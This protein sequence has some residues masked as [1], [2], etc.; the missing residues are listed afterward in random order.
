MACPWSCACDPPPP[1]I[2]VASNARPY[3]K[4]GGKTLNRREEG[5]QY[6]ISQTPDQE[7]FEARKVVFGG[8]VSTFLQLVVAEVSNDKAKM[9]KWKGT[10]GQRG[11]LWLFTPG[12]CFLLTIL[13]DPWVGKLYSKPFLFATIYPMLELPVPISDLGSVYMR[14]EFHC[15]KLRVQQSGKG[16]LPIITYTG[17]L[18]WGG[19]SL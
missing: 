12:T 10:W 3:S 11:H 16:V 4:L 19:Y 1:L 2:K 6:Y 18:R 17:R 13:V 5:G 9:R 15:N 14:M 8:T 7:Q